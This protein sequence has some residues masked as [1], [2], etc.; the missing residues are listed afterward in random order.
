M[1][2]PKNVALI[3]LAVATIGGAWLAWQQHQELV[4]LRAAAMN[5]DERAALQRRLWDLE[6]NN[7]AL[8]RQLATQRGSSPGDGDG[9]GPE[10]GAFPGGR[11]G[12]GNNPQAAFTAIRTL[13]GKPEVQ[14]L[15]SVQQKAAIDSRYA[16]LFKSMNLSPEQADKVKTLLADRITTMQ[17]VLNAALDQGID[18]RSDPAGFRKLVAD[19]QA[20]INDNLQSLLGDS[21]FAQLQTYDQTMPQRN[22]VNLLQQRLSY[23]DTPLTQT[24][25][26]Q[27]VQILA[28]NTPPPAPRLNA[29][30]TPMPAGPG[31]G[32]L[33][34][35]GG[36]ATGIIV[37]VAGGAL[38]TDPAALGLA[39]IRGGG[40]TAPI[41]PAAVS[42]ASSVLA[43]PQVA[44]LQ[45]L[46]QQQQAQQRL[47]QIVR[48]TLSGQLPAGGA[49][50]GAA[51]NA[52]PRPG[53]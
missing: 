13:L 38:G 17:D 16:S 8:T 33:G 49:A 25:A 18:P 44:A 35:I 37:A 47:Q 21:G 19:A 28:T 46:E 27:L 4:G 31:G 26:D 12:R 52:S 48:E 3:L 32:G 45:Q 2:S 7:Q 53:G 51:G 39:G 20:G 15:L 6:K 30:G 1:I 50:G 43:A 24:Q 42:Q 10:R 14:A 5:K 34:G 36:D 41:T 22:V 11:G 9:S 23:T 40:A 29:E